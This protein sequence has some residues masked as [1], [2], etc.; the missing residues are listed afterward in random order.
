MNGA[1]NTSCHGGRYGRTPSLQKP[2]ARDEVF[3][4]SLE[5]VAGG[6]RKNGADDERI[7]REGGVDEN[8]E[9]VAQVLDARKNRGHVVSPEHDVRDQHVEL[10]VA[11][12]GGFEFG[13]A[14]GAARNLHVK[15]ARETLGD[16]VALRLIFGGNEDAQRFA[17]GG[18]L[19]E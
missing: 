1:Q 19:P 6:A 3:L 16:A 4:V 12:H 15:C 10:C 7:L 5:D 17:D 2:H 13:R 14:R 9:I 11:A 8:V 18:S